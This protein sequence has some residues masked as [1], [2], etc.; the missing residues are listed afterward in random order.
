MSNTLCKLS[1][2]LFYLRLSVDLPQSC[3]IWSYANR[4]ALT[5]FSVDQSL[6]VLTD[7]SPYVFGMIYYIVT[8][9]HWSV[10]LIFQLTLCLYKREPRSV[11]ADRNR[12][13][14]ALF[15][16]IITL[17]Y[18]FLWQPTVLTVIHTRCQCI[19]NWIKITTQLQL[20]IS[21]PKWY[22]HIQSEKQIITHHFRL[23]RETRLSRTIETRLS[24]TIETRLSRNSRLNRNFQYIPKLFS[25]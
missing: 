14:R 13:L 16:L 6:C 18:V 22:H 11:W 10:Q 19:L 5:Y 12:D 15:T 20:C 25:A 9:F 3:I 2:F 17:R 21:L 4:N 7:Q 8:V 24:R 23:N 1:T